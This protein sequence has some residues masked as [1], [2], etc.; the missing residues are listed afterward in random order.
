MSSLAQF[1]FLDKIN[2]CGR[3]SFYQM[4]VGGGGRLIKSSSYFT[5][6]SLHAPTVFPL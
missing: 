5:Q 4:N 1:S 2:S 3:L 6:K